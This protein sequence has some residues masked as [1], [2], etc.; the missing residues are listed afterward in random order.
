VPKADGR[1][2]SKEETRRKLLE[3]GLALL[4]EE[5]KEKLA[6]IVAPRRVISKAGSSSGAFYHH[7]DGQDGFLDQLM[8]HSTEGAPVFEVMTGYESFI[9]V[10]NGGGTFAEAVLAAGAQAVRLIGTDTTVP[11]QYLVR[12]KVGRDADAQRRLQA[13]YE[14][15]NE[16]TAAVY[17]SILAISNRE[18]RPPFTMRDLVTAILAVYEG[19]MSRRTITPEDVPEN[20]L[21]A[22]MLV[23]LDLYTRPESD[24]TDRDARLAELG[25]GWT[26]DWTPA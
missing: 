18:L 15:I 8:E 17:E 26:L 3:A 25:N 5:P 4:R 7:F 2:A 13:M 24:D 1:S 10:M 21:G 9:E 11:L 19:F 23:I 22:I 20:S 12:A 16:A 14:H 6:E